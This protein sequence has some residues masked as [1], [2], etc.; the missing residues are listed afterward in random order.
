VSSVER[1]LELLDQM[2]QKAGLEPKTIPAPPPVDPESVTPV[3]EDLVRRL[4]AASEAEPPEPSKRVAR[5]P[6]KKKGS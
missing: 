3:M 6:R 4:L 1:V 5:K 2:G